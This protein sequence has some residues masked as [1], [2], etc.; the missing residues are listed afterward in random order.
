MPAAPAHM[1]PTAN[2]TSSCAAGGEEPLKNRN[3]A[4]PHNAP[5]PPE[6]TTNARPHGPASAGSGRRRQ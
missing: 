5:A 3:A 4:T 1:P 6:P 2:V